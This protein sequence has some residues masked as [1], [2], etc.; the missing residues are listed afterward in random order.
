[1]E[2]CPA[3][4]KMELKV[5]RTIDKL[6][7]IH[8]DLKVLI[9]GFNAMNGSLKEVK[10]KADNHISVESPIYRKKVDE[11]WAGVHFSKWVI[12]LIGG[13]GILWKIIEIA[14]K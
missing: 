4:E 8:T 2:Q 6:D 9:A 11:L 5:D 10:L 12:I 13:S 7:S 14:T 1:M 3:H